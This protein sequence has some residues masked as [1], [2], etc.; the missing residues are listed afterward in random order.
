M[1]LIRHA[2]MDD[3]VQALATGVWVAALSFL[4]GFVA[5]VVMIPA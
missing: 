1:K 3:P 5:Y 2:P 4:T